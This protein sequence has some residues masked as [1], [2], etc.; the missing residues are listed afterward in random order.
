MLAVESRRFKLKVLYIF[1]CIIIIII[2]HTN[3]IK[4]NCKRRKQSR[5]I[6]INLT[7]SSIG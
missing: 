4:Y 5:Y 1:S 6:I 3:R 7:E 2:E